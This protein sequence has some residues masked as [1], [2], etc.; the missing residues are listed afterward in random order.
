M[1]CRWE[2][3]DDRVKMKLVHVDEVFSKSVATTL[4]DASAEKCAAMAYCV[5][6]RGEM[7]GIAYR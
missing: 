6:L 2:S 3:P 5:E 7:R 1:N 4:M